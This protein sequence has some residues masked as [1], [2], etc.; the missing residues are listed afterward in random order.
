M[1]DY[2]TVI[3]DQDMV[4]CFEKGMERLYAMF[5]E[6][7][8]A[9]VDY[10]IKAEIRGDKHKLYHFRVTPDTFERPGGRPGKSN[11]GKKV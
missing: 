6:A 7:M 10:T 9:G 3:S 11:N 5:C 1:P 8:M 2:K 4:V